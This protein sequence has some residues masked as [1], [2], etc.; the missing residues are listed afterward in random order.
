MRHRTFPGFRWSLLAILLLASASTASSFAAPKDGD[1]APGFK[2]RSYDGESVSLSD[3]SGKVVVLSF[4]AS[5]CGP[6]LKELP[7]LEGIQKSAGKDRIQVMAINIEDRQTFRKVAR[8][9]QAAQSLQMLVVSDAAKQTQRAYDVKA[10][11]MMV[12]IDKAGKILRIH[13][14]YSEAGLGKVVD[15]LNEALG[16]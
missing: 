9:M 6:C 12:I 5:W 15:D 1:A 14:G 10:I 4:W 13:Q 3:Y 7:I 2:V 11:P 8:K 16:L